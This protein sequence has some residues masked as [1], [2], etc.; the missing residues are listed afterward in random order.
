MLW[1]FF[2]VSSAILNRNIIFSV[3][4]LETD[5]SELKVEVIFAITE[6]LQVHVRQQEWETFPWTPHGITDLLCVA[7]RDRGLILYFVNEV[8]ATHRTG[9]CLEPPLVRSRQITHVN[10]GL[11]F[12]LSQSGI[13]RFLSVVAVTFGETPFLAQSPFHDKDVTLVRD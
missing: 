11:F 7:D 12:Q 6:G 3:G 1:S 4:R 13:E 8:C 10:A 5:V 9:L 2:L